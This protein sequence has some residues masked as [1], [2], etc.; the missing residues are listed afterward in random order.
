MTTSQK[1][2]GCGQLGRV[3]ME[4]LT[5]GEKKLGQADGDLLALR[6][7]LNYSGFYFFRLQPSKVPT[8]FDESH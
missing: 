8:L 2:L 3:D 7:R 1:G 6:L 5:G 4:H